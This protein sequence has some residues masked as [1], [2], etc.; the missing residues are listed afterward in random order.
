MDREKNAGSFAVLLALVAVFAGCGRQPG[1]DSP[2][3]DDPSAM[4]RHSFELYRDEGVESSLGYVAENMLDFNGKP[5]NKEKQEAIIHFFSTRPGT[6]PLVSWEV[7]SEEI[8]G[9]AAEIEHTLTKKRG[10]ET[11]TQ[12]TRSFLKKK[13]GRWWFVL[14]TEQ[15]RPE[16]PP[17][18]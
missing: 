7:H 11:Y 15:K 12:R 3:T 5:L 10:S 13:E 14:D 1:A 16:A 6:D 8:S 4:V 9:S 2:S 18:K 17:S